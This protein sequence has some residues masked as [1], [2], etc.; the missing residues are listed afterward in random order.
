M[1][2]TPPQFAKATQSGKHNATSQIDFQNF[3]FKR[4]KILA[5]GE[6]RGSRGDFILKYFCRSYQLKTK[7]DSAANQCEFH[8]PS[9]QN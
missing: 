5:W 6:G 9:K 4:V 7:N 3:K 2:S 1:Y 8:C